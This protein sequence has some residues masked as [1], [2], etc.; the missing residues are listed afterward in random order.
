MACGM[1]GELTPEG[2]AQRL[3]DSE[4]MAARL[5]LATKRPVPV[6]AHPAAARAEAALVDAVEA[7]SEEE[8]GAAE[9]TVEV[10]RR[11]P[12]EG[13]YYPEGAPRHSDNTGWTLADGG[14][15]L[16]DWEGNR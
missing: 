6:V 7:V 9:I 1:L 15:E 13:P 5:A 16:Y 4:A 8:V 14:R 12:G 3:A 10:R 11:L 2:S